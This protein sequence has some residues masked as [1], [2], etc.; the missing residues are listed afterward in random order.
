MRL[1]KL[2]VS[3][4]ALLVGS[5]SGSCVGGDDA[6]NDGPGTIDASVDASSD[7]RALDARLTDAVVDAASPLGQCRS[8]TK[9]TGG[10]CGG[11]HCQQ[12]FEQLTASATTG[13]ACSGQK[14]LETLCSLRGP[15]EVGKCS[16][17]NATSRPNIPTCA[18]NA[19]KQDVTPACLQCY[20]KSADCAFDNCLLEC[21]SGTATERC[22][23]CRLQKG[24]AA[25]FFEC[26]GIA[27][28]PR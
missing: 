22:D 10:M 28:P 20:L 11:P 1:V 27:P 16:L 9:P 17:A 5:F 21:V 6:E 23:L 7:A 19:L 24:C 3:A 25:T 26:A 14:D 12:T 13:G 15:D 8:W 18:A 4:F 2:Y